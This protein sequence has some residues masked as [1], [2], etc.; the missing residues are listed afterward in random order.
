LFL[1]YAL[2]IV[3][4]ISAAIMPSLENPWLKTISSIVAVI[5]TSLVTFLSAQK[6]SII[7]FQAWRALDLA[8]M[9]YAIDETMTI[10]DVYQ[11]IKRREEIIEAYQNDALAPITATS[12]PDPNH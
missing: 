12:K 10:D 11:V 1:H 5:C 2:G 3:G 6:H 7:F 4:I 8:L 9:K